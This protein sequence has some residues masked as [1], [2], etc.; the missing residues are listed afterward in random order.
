M[1]RV[2]ISF[3]SP[4]FFPSL[5]RESQD[6]KAQKTEFGREDA[7]FWFRLFRVRWNSL[8][9]GGFTLRRAAH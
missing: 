5:C 4:L 1:R 6:T 9:R 2:G 8:V 7:F 3:S